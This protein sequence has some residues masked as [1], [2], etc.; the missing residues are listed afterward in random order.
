MLAY[1]K[2]LQNGFIII[3]TGRVNS[4]LLWLDISSNFL[5]VK[6]FDGEQVSD[7]IDQIEY[8]DDNDAEDSEI[9]NSDEEN[10][11]DGEI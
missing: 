9:D 7:R 5:T 6:W 2:T 8:R 11:S 4:Y 10:E 1:S 3:P